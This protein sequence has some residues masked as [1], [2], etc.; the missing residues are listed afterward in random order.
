MR[1]RQTENRKSEP[2]SGV[3][4]DLLRGHGQV[5][6][7]NAVRIS[8]GYTLRS[9]EA[10]LFGLLWGIGSGFVNMIF[11]PSHRGQILLGSLLWAF[12]ISYLSMIPWRIRILPGRQRPFWAVLLANGALALVS[13]YVLFFALLLLAI[14]TCDG[15]RYLHQK[16]V[17]SAIAALFA[18]VFP[19]VGLPITLGADAERRGRKT[20]LAV[21]RMKKL[22]QQAQLIALRAQV[23]PHFFFNSLNAIAALIPERPRDAERAVELLAEALRPA[24]MR[25][26]RPVGTVESEVRIARAYAELEQLRFGDRL[27][28]TFNI[29]AAVSERQ[30]MSLC[31]QPLIENAVRHGAARTVD[32]YCIETSVHARGEGVEVVVRNAPE[33]RLALLG[34]DDLQPVRPEA[35]HALAN[36]AARARGIHGS[37][38]LI[39]VRVDSR[40]NGIAE[41]HLP[42]I[43]QQML[44]QLGEN[45]HTAEIFGP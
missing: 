41:L 36:L 9:R 21:Q 40:G 5:D 27:S 43:S 45:I 29:D 34:T 16:L 11:Y 7:R 1:L 44:R 14:V 6:L 31:L 4:I 37:G 42:P 3:R 24:L 22:A 15:T 32:R 38:A 10:L 18:F 13:G 33:Q 19:L 2:S 12:A 26:Q 17:S 39:D 20:A 28:F 30:V 35:G 25:D 8:L 23:N